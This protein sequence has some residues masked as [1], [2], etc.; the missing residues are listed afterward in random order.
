M[1]LG[2]MSGCGTLDIEPA[3]E[4]SQ[5]EK[6]ETK[7]SGKET[8]AAEASEAESVSRE[9]EAPEAADTETESKEAS[10]TAETEAPKSDSGEQ[11]DQK[12]KIEKN[13][14]VYILFT[15]D[16][17]CGIDE[18]FG[19][20]G[21]K[22]IRDR[23]E[24]E[25]Y[26]TILVDDGDAIQ[27]EAVGT[28]TKG[29]DIVKIMNKLDYDLAIPGNHEFD[30]GMEDF[31]KLAE[32]EAEY[33]Y[34]SCNFTKNDELVF[35]P[36]AIKEAAGMKIGFVGV[37]TPTSLT[38][39]TPK[40]FQDEK[41]NFIYGFLQDETG[42]K[43]Y[44]AVQKAVDDVRKEGADLVYVIGHMG[45]FEDSSP[46]TYKDII[47]HTEGIDVFLDGHSHD[48]EQVVMKDKSG[49]EVTRSAVGT[50]LNCIGYSHISADKEIEK[51]DIWSWPNKD[52][53][54]ELLGID[55]EISD[56]VKEIKAELDQKMGE[57]VAKTEVDLTVN[58]PEEKDNKGNPIRMVRR[59]ETN[60]GDFCADA[61]RWSSGADI[62]IAN[63]GSIR[64]NIE[65]GDITYSDIIDVFPYGNMI[66]MIEVTG[67]QVLDAL[68]WGAR[69]VP[70][71]CGGFL[72][73]SGLSYEINTKI[74]SPCIADDNTMFMEIK[75]E[76]RVQNVKVGDKPIDP[77]A[78][79]T[80]ACHDYTIQDKG[81]GYTMFDG[82][83]VIEDRVKLDNQVLIEYI[84]E[85]LGGLIG[86][87]YSD[88]YG[89][90]RIKIIQ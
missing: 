65:K 59:A 55:N 69:S 18:G 57:V 49:K 78:T 80:L 64:A 48:T 70:D 20:A 46:W 52:S 41:G 63:G 51:T 45:M 5:T 29:E 77:K 16:V 33:K 15:S 8:V 39:S 3:L 26:E 1:M 68:E 43:V 53:A 62:G 90:G 84:T 32:N 40:Y 31:L 81:D 14:E 74:D 60:I 75:G 83:K 89:Q 6:A 50:K 67:Q 82:A 66:S 4:P 88:P 56:M 10:V 73:V 79:Y 25:G 9:T 2:N 72:Q 36:Y 23:L 13:G 76:R 12:E 27:G 47:E 87:Q 86:G 35:E 28:V 61:Y 85:E 54:P 17:H 38:T 30:Y 11:S 24:S 34:I 22:A 44:D 7:D 71:E 37:T 58:D 19:Y 21:L 42:E